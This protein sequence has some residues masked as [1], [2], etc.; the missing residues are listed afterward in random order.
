[1]NSNG[2]FP[3]KDIA[4]ALPGYHQQD[5]V[6][7]RDGAASADF[8]YS[9]GDEA[10]NYLLNLIEGAADR[11]LF[12]AEL[13]A[14]IK[15]WASIYHLSPKRANLLRPFA[16]LLRSNVLEVGA[17]CGA[18]TRYLGENGGSI[19][20]IEGSARRAKIA[21]LRTADLP[22][23]RVVCDRIEE[24]SS[25]QRFD[26]ITVVGVLE[27]AR[28][29]QQRAGDAQI[30]MMAALRKLLTPD[31]V[32]FLAIENK[33]GLKYFAGAREDHAGVPF[34]GIN[35]NY[36]PQ[37][38]ATF[39]REELA[40]IL[41]RTGFDHQ[42]WYIPCPDYKLPMTVLA[43]DI[44]KG[45]RELA[46]TLLSQS[47]TLDPQ[48]ASNPT[49]SLERSWSEIYQNGLVEHLANSFLVAAGSS[50]QSLASLEASKEIAWHYAVDRYPAFTKQTRFVKE[51]DGTTVARD[52]LT[53]AEPP[54]VPLQCLAKDEPYWPGRNWWQ[55]LV[56]I[57][58]VPGWTVSQIAAWARVWTDALLKECNIPELNAA[59]FQSIV[60]GSH[61]DAAPFNM[62]RDAFGKTTFFDQEWHIKPKIEFGYIV[63]RGLKD[64]L[65]R[66]TSYAPP[67]AGTPLNAN[68]LIVAILADM[69]VFVTKIEFDR[70]ALMESQVQAWVQG[71]LDVMPADEAISRSWAAALHVRSAVEREA[72]ARERAQIQ[73]LVNEREQQIAVLCSEIDAQR[74]R[75]A[76]QDNEVAR[77]IS[78]ADD[79]RK[80]T[81]AALAMLSQTERRRDLLTKEL[82]TARVWLQETRS[83]SRSLADRLDQAQTALATEQS[84]HER[85]RLE[86]ARLAAEELE[87]R[88]QRDA[89][90]AAETER[91]QEVTAMQAQAE[92]LRDTIAQQA[93]TIDAAHARRWRLS[94]PLTAAMRRLSRW[95]RTDFGPRA[96]EVTTIRASRLFS[97]LWY[98]K[99]NPDVMAAGN[100]A[101]EHYLSHGAREG[102]DPH[103]LFDSRWYREQYPQVADAKMSPLTHYITVGISEGLDPHPLFDTDFYL[104]TNPDVAA[105]GANPLHHYMAHGAYEGRDPHPLFDSSWYL[106]RN[107]DVAAARDNPLV[108]YLTHGAKEGRDP[109]PD[110][111]ASWYLEQ[112]HD[113]AKAGTD[114]LVHY[115]LHGK[116]EGRIAQPAGPRIRKPQTQPHIS[117]QLQTEVLPAVRP[118]PL[119]VDATVP[120]STFNQ[121]DVVFISGLPDNTSHIYR[122]EHQVDALNAVGI[123][124]EW[125]PVDKIDFYQ[126]RI[127]FSHVVVLFRL[128]W[129][130]DVA[131]IIEKCRKAGV[132]IL[133]DIDDY[134]FDLAVTTEENVDGLRF[135]PRENLPQYF[136]GVRRYRETAENADEG[137][138]TTEFL[139][140]ACRNLGKPAHVVRNGFSEQTIHASARALDELRGIKDSTSVRLGYASGSMTHQ[141]DFA[142]AA[143]AI[144]K[145][146]AEHP[147]VF[148]MVVG[149]LQLDEFP[150]LQR[151]ADRIEQRSLV[152][153]S[154]L[155]MELA[156][157]DINLAPLELGNP[158]CEAKSELKYYE[159]ALVSVPTIATATA[160]FAAAITH[161]VTGFLADDIEGWYAALKKLVQSP[162]LRQQVA[163][164]AYQ[165]AM[166]EY[167]PEAKQRQLEAVFRPIIE[168]RKSRLRES[169]DSYNQTVT[170][171]VPGMIK[172]SGGHNKILS[173]VKWL[174]HLGY[175]VLVT[176]TEA[177]DHY[178]TPDLIADDFGFDDRYVRIIYSD[179]LAVCS[180]ITFATYWKTV[181][182][183][184]QS[185]CWAGRRFHFL[186]DYEPYFFAMGTDY[187]LAMN[188]MYKDFHKISY[189]PWI[190]SIIAQRHGLEA[191][192][193]PFYIDQS[194]YRVDPAADRKRNRVLYFARPEMPRR[195]FDLGVEALKIFQQ[196]YGTEVEIV[197]F[198][199][200]AVGGIDL[201]FRCVDL[202]VLSPQELVKCYNEATVGLVFSPTN[203]S[204]VPFEM[205]ACGL[206]VI[207]LDV[208]GNTGNYGG[209]ENA[210]LVIP[211]P[212]VIAERIHQILID[213]ELRERVARNGQ[214]F[215]SVMCAEEEAIQRLVKII[216]R[217]S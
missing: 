32:I 166:A 127:I 7:F 123:P 211:D 208:E 53:D 170:F 46:A 156:R 203:P 133:F 136:D 178:P 17:G 78:Q 14:G 64:S 70:Y 90:A 51:R 146:M 190:K 192:H 197:L 113:V 24:F 83:E 81:E 149:L 16:G 168:A 35:G 157:F 183:I 68:Q 200:Y 72:L 31:G 76:S 201:P 95:K 27:Y 80:A 110:F 108:H 210:F 45:Y 193:M 199:S 198:G 23:V 97:P 143:P 217:A 40:S 115:A 60:D 117:A 59:T 126:H 125:Y 47:T 63:F 177:T 160:T 71:R 161:G 111:D 147:N 165:H 152:A 87:I 57:G 74:T 55:E 44:Q 205:M 77:A 175:T 69:G 188:A 155:P 135:L 209:R 212:N 48:R 121:P 103:P 104:R 37:S 20:A 169:P 134:V 195:C 159:A 163:V 142:V 181:Y 124:T 12:S 91:R 186:Q 154:E 207:D 8:S 204:M 98:L 75:I 130:P 101:L 86:R 150:E 50:T 73:T 85:T 145:I 10:E 216:D 42:R 79:Q 132:R 120:H 6:Y 140:E 174:A 84:V 18:L 119:V 102:R 118:Q 189:G 89:V 137:I 1:M 138:L 158:F 112:H 167:G 151:F 61:F 2:A 114:A 194:I 129:G 22:N 96:W 171:M 99:R 139:A 9:D 109:H 62:V 196:T 214:T 26:V 131:R 182:N 180:N 28:L 176:F 164:S 13:A 94:S 202:G 21:R 39:G 122:V 187:L 5:G 100:D 105:A 82:E 206:P 106:E 52:T 92:T 58:N 184:E 33:L 107:P 54:A 93:A 148:L 116:A 34:H 153:H 43:P 25:R 56:A 215:A 191:D 30:D 15:D 29:Y 162:S 213:G 185:K 172:G 66:V 19:T 88:R 65:M 173:L 67:A 41:D 38:V 49:F 3:A 128:A 36:G 4:D 179:R 141:R 144:A 11:S